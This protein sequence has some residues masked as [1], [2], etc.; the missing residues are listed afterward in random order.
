MK[1]VETTIA[2]AILL[3]AVTMTEGFN[4]NEFVYSDTATKNNIENVPSPDQIENGKALFEN[5][6]KPL[7]DKYGEIRIT[8]AYRNQELNTLVG[9]VP[10]SQ[11]MTG[12]AVDIQTPTVSR[13]Q[14]AQW[15]IENLEYD[16]LII[17]P[18]WL[19]ISYSRTKNRKEN[20][21]YYR[22]SLVP[23]KYK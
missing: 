3:G 2:G 14:V 18:T 8:S 23:Y 22:G 20:L 9:G 19:H 21:K 6:I 12:Q 5:I 11:H 4:Y 16:Q 7:R 17:E 1:I 10:N 13:Y 15:I